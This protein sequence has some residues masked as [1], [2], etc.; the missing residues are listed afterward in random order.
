MAKGETWKKWAD[1]NIVRV[2]INLNRTNDA[3]IIEALDRTGEPKGTA[4]KRLLR[5]ALELDNNAHK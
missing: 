5:A 1:D 4:V 2:Y 3:D